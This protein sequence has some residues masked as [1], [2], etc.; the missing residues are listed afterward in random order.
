MTNDKIELAKMTARELIAY[1][2]SLQMG[3]KMLATIGPDN[4]HEAIV[5]ELLDERSIPHKENKLIKIV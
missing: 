1:W 4:G 3:K 5:D 2:N